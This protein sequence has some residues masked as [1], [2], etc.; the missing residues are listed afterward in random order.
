MKGV[1]TLSEECWYCSMQ[2]L[3]FL[4]SSSSSLSH[5]DLP[6]KGTRQPLIWLS[7][8]SATS[9]SRGRRGIHTLISSW[10]VRKPKSQPRVSLKPPRNIN[11]I[12]R[13]PVPVVLRGRRERGTSPTGERNE[14]IKSVVKLTYLED[15]LL[16]RPTAGVVGHIGDG[17]IGLHRQSSQRY[18]HRLPRQ[19][20]SIQ[21]ISVLGGKEGRIKIR[22]MPTSLT[23]P[24]NSR[25]QETV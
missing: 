14:L 22:M 24:G 19:D 25:R 17:A 6:H 9:I 12:C 16:R 8:G 21:D 4:I 1:S 3:L 2:P 15:I 10:A 7:S 13:V 20:G 11:Y 5:V 18:R 23:F